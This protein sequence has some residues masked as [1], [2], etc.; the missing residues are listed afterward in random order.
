MWA[1]ELEDENGLAESNLEG[2]EQHRS[3][4][5]PLAGFQ[6]TTEDM[7][8]NERAFLVNFPPGGHYC[9]KSAVAR[10]ND[11]E[12]TWKLDEETIDGVS[13]DQSGLI[14]VRRN[15]PLRLLRGGQQMAHYF[16][17]EMDYDFLQYT[18]VDMGE[19]DV[20]YLWTYGYPI[21]DIGSLEAVGG[22]CFRFRQD[23]NV[24]ILFF[25]LQ[26]IW[27]HPYLRHKGL[28]K[29]AWPYCSKRFGW[30]A[31]ELISDNRNSRPYCLI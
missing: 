18:A 28:L 23:D 25:A 14:A 30:F 31:M 8:A 12:A 17:R 16:Q 4:P 13:A 22:C 11:I 3:G 2:V 6:V 20:A 5:S 1:S 10:A 24:K 7:I 19:S 26:W 9:I 27:I 15:S 29:G 21:D